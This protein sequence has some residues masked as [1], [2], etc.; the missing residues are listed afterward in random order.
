[1]ARTYQCWR[2]GRTTSDEDVKRREVNRW[3]GGSRI[4]V[5]SQRVNVCPECAA[6]LDRRGT[7]KGALW[8]A[9]LAAVVV[10]FVF[11]R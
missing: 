5:R 8:L 2:C 11:F 7:I 9:A 1:M 10:Y 6:A 3:S 4:Y